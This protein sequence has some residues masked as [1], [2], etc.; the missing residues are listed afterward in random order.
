[1]DEG[2]PIQLPLV[3]TGQGPSYE[4]LGPGQCALPDG[5]EPPGDHEYHATGTADDIR[6]LCTSMPDCL[7]YSASV[8]GGGLIWKSDQLS[9]GGVSWGS[10]HC[11]RKVQP[12]YENLGLGKCVLPDGS[13]PAHEYHG[14]GT[15][16]EMKAICTSACCCVGYSA[17]TEGGGLIWKSGQLSGGG[18]SWG[19]TH[20]MRK[21]A[22]S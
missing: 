20:C 5:S 13:D 2:L 1:M 4:D 22:A 19:N 7:G 8:I 3:C 18:V 12:V 17:S 16:A 15:H 10:S 14:T 21:V 11:M 9:G 6:A